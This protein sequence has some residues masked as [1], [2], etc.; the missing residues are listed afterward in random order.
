MTEKTKQRYKENR[1]SKH[2]QSTD[3]RQLTRPTDTCTHARA[4][5][6]KRDAR[7]HTGWLMKAKNEVFA[8]LCKDAH[9][10]TRR[11][12]FLRGAKKRLQVGA[13]KISV[14]SQAIFMLLWAQ[15]VVSGC[16]LECLTRP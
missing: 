12:D 14:I 5:A 11:E 10:G 2:K 7:L 16:V 9:C 4:H 1:K 13:E 15:H 8:T 6:R 3:P